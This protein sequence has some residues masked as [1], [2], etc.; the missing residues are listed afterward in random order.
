[1]KRRINA[2]W[3]GDGSNEK[4]IL[5]AQSGAFNDM[6]IPSKQDLKM[7]VVLLERILKNLLQLLSLDV[8][9]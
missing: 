8:S 3:T 6:L 5:N 1:M 4:G 2:I 9:I 7:M